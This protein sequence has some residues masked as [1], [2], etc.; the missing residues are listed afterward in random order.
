MINQTNCIDT[1]NLLEVTFKEIYV[2]LR[3]NIRYLLVRILY[4]NRYYLEVFKFLQF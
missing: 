3:K 1:S 4:Y 2:K